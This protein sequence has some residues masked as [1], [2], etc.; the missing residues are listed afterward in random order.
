M[1]VLLTIGG[2]GGA[3]RAEVHGIEAETL[4]G[5]ELADQIQSNWRA[6]N[7]LQFVVHK[8]TLTW[9]VPVD[10][11]RGYRLWMLG[12]SGWSK[13]HRFGGDGQYFAIVGDR[14]LVLTAQR[15][16]LLFQTNE[17][18]FVWFRSEPF[19]LAPGRQT[20]TAGCTWD[21]GKIDGMVL[22]NEPFEPPKPGPGAIPREI[23]NLTFSPT[24]WISDP[25]A[26]FNTG[27]APP[28]DRSEPRIKL[29]AARNASAYASVRIH[30]PAGAVWPAHLRLRM[31]ALKTNEGRALPDD[32]VSLHR[33]ATLSAAFGG[34]GLVGTDALP[35]LGPLGYVELARG[36]TG[37]VWVV[38]RMGRDQEPGVYRGSLVLED[39]HT[40]TRMKVPVEVELANVNLPDRTDLAVYTWWRHTYASDA[41]WD[42]IVNQGINTF[43]VIILGPV[44]YTFDDDANL[45]GE[46]RFHEDLRHFVDAQERTGGY[47]LIEWYFRGG[48]PIARSMQGNGEGDSETDFKYMTPAWKKAFAALIKEVHG[49]FESRGLPRERLLHYIFDENLS[50]SFIETA[51][52]IKDLD[53]TY[54]V[55]N[56][57]WGDL[58]TFKKAA[59][60]VDVWCPHVNHL[61][62]MAKDGLM[63]YLRSTGKPIW[64]YDESYHQRAASPY[65]KYRYKFW[66]TYKYDLQGCG[67]WKH[68]GLPGLTYEPNYG[69]RVT[70]R[71]YEGW[72]SGIEDYKL[73][74]M[75]EAFAESGAQAAGEA[76]TLLDEAVREVCA[77]SADTRRAAA[78]RDRIIRL[79]AKENP[80][81]H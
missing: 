76:K 54:K 68:H 65:A 6:S 51:R 14:K 29:L 67:F 59:P 38:L 49:Y 57:G 52:F 75:L 30:H 79:L 78:Y 27:M 5:P 40:M 39:Q 46:C 24:V 66:L 19:E 56:N 8:D 55:F 43:G 58:E 35:R 4:V 61:A 2:P 25:Y 13:D 3:A 48:A 44:A 15:Q 62:G 47:Q 53:P 37:C 69:T 33:L 18:N 74:T 28:D 64:S 81:S 34:P 9:T 80:S 22:T 36:T 20:F 72:M 60:Y 12:R 7:R 17:S 42:E 16:T 23:Q 21:W 32:C 41:Q 45:V 70:S 50:D 31:T 63:D 77:R 1:G 71:R 11:G 10:G 73:L 26:P